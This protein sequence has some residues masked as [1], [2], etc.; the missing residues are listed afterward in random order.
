MG[1]DVVV[2]KM[3]VIVQEQ[4]ESKVSGVSF[5]INPV[6]NDY[7]EIVINAHE[8]MGDLL[9]AGQVTPETW[10]IDKQK[11]NP[12]DV[13]LE[14]AAAR[15]QANPCLD[16]D[17]AIALAEETIA[18]EQL[19]EGPVDVEWAIDDDG[20]HLLQVRPV[21][22]WL[23]LPGEMLTEPSEPRLL[24]FDPG[25]ADG[26]TISSALSRSTIDFY[27]YLLRAIT[28]MEMSMWYPQ[29]DPKSSFIFSNGLRFYCNLSWVLDFINPKQL[30]EDRRV[31]DVELA[32][33]YE[34][35]DFSPYRIRKQR[36]KSI[37]TALKH[38]YRVCRFMKPLFRAQFLTVF[39]PK[40]FIDEYFQS[41]S[42]F[43]RL[44]ENPNFDE[45]VDRFV[46]RYASEWGRTFLDATLPAVIAL[47]YGALKPLDKLQQKLPKE[48][49]SKIEDVR[50]GGENLV[51]EMGSELTELANLFSEGSFDNLD[52]LKDAIDQSTIDPVI[53]SAWNR[54]VVRFGCR[55]PLEMELAVPKYGDDPE[56]L[57]KQLA[58]I[59]EIQLTDPRAIYDQRRSARDTAFEE[60]Q[61]SLVKSKRKRLLKARGALELFEQSRELPKHHIC[62]VSSMVRKR[63]LLLAEKLREANRIDRSED[64]FDLTISEMAEVER[65]QSIDIRKLIEKK[66]RFAR[67][68]ASRVKH[69]P[70]LIDSRGRIVRA[71]AT[72]S[73]DKDALSGVSVS[74]GFA[75]GPAV[76]M[77]D[78]FQKILNPGDVLVAHTT[79]PGWTPLFINA[80]A[81]VL[82]IGGQLQH[83]ALVA[84]EYGKPCI[85]GVQGATSRI[86]DGQL[87]QVDAD[88]GSVRVFSDED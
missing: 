86:Q 84:R 77:D 7:D 12:I 58:S 33:T 73:D 22:S 78:P 1:F 64:I 79:D 30:A 87:L 13:Q 83:G 39:A 85:V 9:V 49:Q 75:K 57:L 29:A 46:H 26:V 14:S 31:F 44:I 80:S 72:E 81:I 76:V 16:L 3:A 24:Y 54:F 32:R 38:G 68:A 34:K 88:A 37:A 62:Q 67:E 5:S 69:F 61:Q 65:D 27:M 36:L 25:L 6:N 71:P 15:I 63:M 19:S 28:G 35:V 41:I 56:V 52:R 70:H 66:C 53:A 48:L 8:G 20:L 60:L 11:L 51:R 55:G 23:Q 45:P 43:S 18:L 10:V 4:V 17:D 47:V 50:G 2:P 82:E 40:R 59:G 21:T 74:R 42:R